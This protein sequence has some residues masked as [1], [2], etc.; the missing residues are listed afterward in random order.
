M[1]SYPVC[2]GVKKN[3]APC[4]YRGKHDGYCKFHIPNECPICYEKM[5]KETS[6]ITSCKHMFHRKC[7]ER[8]TEE[9]QTCP[10]C[11]ENIRP[12]TG[13]LRP[14]SSP[15]IY[16]NSYEELIPY[17]NAPIEIRFTSNYWNNN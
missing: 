13:S 3:G 10:L 6:T 17:I 15:V 11:R 9:R 4:S 7:L 2:K 14:V 5:T 1:V 12:T 16:V 8:W